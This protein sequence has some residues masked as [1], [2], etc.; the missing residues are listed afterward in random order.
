MY[1]YLLWL[2]IFV[3][4]P[5]ILLWSLNFSYLIKYRVVFLLAIIGSLLFAIPW[6]II[7]VNE[8]IWYFTEPEIIGIWIF[9][10]PI[11][12]YL[13]IFLLTFFVS[14]IALLLCKK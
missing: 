12:E 13:F 6:D 10:L 14:T 8:N 4:I 2:I 9:N 5:L 11:E 3:V 7:A 1:E